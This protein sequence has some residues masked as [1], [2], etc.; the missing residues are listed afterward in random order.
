MLGYDDMDLI[1]SMTDTEVDI[2]I[3][4]ASLRPGHAMKL[5]RHL[6]TLPP[7]SSQDAVVSVAVLDCQRQSSVGDA[8]NASTTSWPTFDRHQTTWAVMLS[9]EWDVQGLVKKVAKELKKLGITVWMDVMHDMN[10]GMGGAH[11][12]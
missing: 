2:M 1:R 11:P 8:S 3:D 10:A 9:Y 4:Q 7:S 5:R 6:G 12:A